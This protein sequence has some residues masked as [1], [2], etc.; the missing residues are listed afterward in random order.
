MIRKSAGVLLA[1]IIVSFHSIAQQQP[2]YKSFLNIRITTE[3]K[4]ADS[5]FVYTFSINNNVGSQQSLEDVRI[6]VGDFRE[7]EGGT[8]KDFINLSTKNWEASV[9]NVTALPKDTTAVALVVWGVGDTTASVDDL[10]QPAPSAVN[11]GESITVRFE[12][13]GLPSIKRF[14]AKGWTKPITEEQL[15]SLH[16]LG[17]ADN[18]IFKPW[19]EEQVQGETIAPIVLG[20]PFDT[21][22]FLDTLLSYTTQSRTLGWITSQTT[23]DK[24]TSYF[25]SAKSNLQTDNINAARAT[26]QQVLSDVNVDSS[27]TL[28]SEAYALLRYNTEYLVSQ[29][30]AQEGGISTYSLFA[31]HSMHLEQNSDVYSGDIGVNAAGLPPFLDEQLELSIGIGTSTAAGYSVKA[32]RIKIKSSS[33]VN[34]NVYYNE[35]DNNGTING[36]QNAPLSLPLVTTLPEF[37]SATPGTENFDIPQNGTLTL[38]PGSY[39]DIMVRKNGVLTMTGGTYHFSSFTTGDDVQLIFQSPSEVRIAGKFDSGQG[40]YIGPQD[41]TTMTADQIIFYVGGINGSNGNLGATPKAAKIGIGNTVW[42]SFYAPN[43]TL[44]IR[45]NSQAKG[46]FIG[47]DVDVGIGA[48]IRR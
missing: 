17:I 32:N 25:T 31:I 14:W 8:L 47:K 48:K 16:A 4:N 40:S 41:T 10:Y 6:E 28:T 18:E 11:P 46:Q 1:M 44:W 39:G 2:W 13:K 20:G 12:S 21:L 38:Q 9:D 24:Y 3:V 30:P 5:V 43:G 45:Q 34:S 27:S 15:D 19:Y 33:V 42:A 35:L 29:L 36:S 23:A 37:K 22:S 7:T 26:L